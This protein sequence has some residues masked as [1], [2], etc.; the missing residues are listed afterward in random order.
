MNVYQVLVCLFVHHQKR[1]SFGA[2][3][4]HPDQCGLGPVHLLGAYGV[5]V[6]PVQANITKYAARTFYFNLTI[7]LRGG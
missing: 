1:G 4:L 7:T 5:S 3:G 6:A 2:L